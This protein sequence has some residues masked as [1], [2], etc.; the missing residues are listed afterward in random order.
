MEASYSELV[1]AADLN[2]NELRLLLA[3]ERTGSFTAAAA[4]LDLTQS[5]VSHAVRTCERKVGAVLFER[6]RTGARPTAAGQRALVHARQILRQLGLLRAEARGAATGSLTGPLH[7]AAFRSAAAH[8]LPPALERLTT[9]HPGLK[10]RVLIVPELGRGTAGEVAD[11]RA[12]VAIA[13]LDEAEEVPDGLVAGE[14]LREPYLLVHPAGHPNPRELPLV[15]WAEN[16]SSYTRA[17]W[18]RQGWLPRATLDVADDSVVLSMIAQGMGMSIL[19]RLTLVSTPPGIEVTP[20]DDDPPTRRV[21]Y[22]ATY[23]TA[24]SLAVRQLVRELRAVSLT[25]V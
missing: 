4:D 17:W 2:P 7:I 13:T 1:D 24:Q 10:P 12:D 19:P 16:C 9:Q 25:A 15:D 20:L 6:G 18:A 23:A 21:V 11:G 14:L 22:I 3:V 5:A 8:L